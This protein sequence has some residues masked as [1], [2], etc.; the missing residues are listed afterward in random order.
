MAMFPVAGA[1]IYIG[2]E[3]DDKNEDFVAADFPA[4]ESPDW[5]EI[6]GWQTMGSIAETANQ[7]TGSLINRGRDYM[8]KG[9]FSAS[10]MD[11]VFV[12]LPDD[13]GQLALRRAINSRRNFA[14]RIVF[15]TGGARMFIALVMSGGDQGGEANTAATMNVQLARNSN[16][17]LV[18]PAA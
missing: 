4:A 11:N 1:R 5:V 10:T 12:I 14:I 13:P 7:I 16:I 15:P 8:M 2:P 18:A 9:T 3:L 17:V 6:D